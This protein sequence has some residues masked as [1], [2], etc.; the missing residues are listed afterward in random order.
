MCICTYVFLLD[1]FA[2][3]YVYVYVLCMCIINSMYEYVLFVIS[4]EDNKHS[5]HRSTRLWC[6]W[7]S[8]E[9]SAARK[10]RDDLARHD[11]ILA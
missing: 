8:G 5:V 6:R 7:E 3:L 2:V 9:V 10:R 1:Q 11:L 4:W